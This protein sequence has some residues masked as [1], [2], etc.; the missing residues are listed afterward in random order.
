MTRVLVA[1]LG[2]IGGSLALN[3]T[4]HTD[5]TLLGYDHDPK[6]LQYAKAKGLVH[7]TYTDFETAVQKA[8]VVILSCP[9]SVTCQLIEDLNTITLTKDVLVTDVSSVKQS[10]L[11]QAEQLTNPQVHFVGGHPMAGSHKRGVE[12]AKEHLFENAIYVLTKTKSVTETDVLRLEELLASTKAK[13]IELD[14]EEH[15]EMTSVIS[16]FP[17]LIASSLVHQA[18]K[19]QEKHPTIPT[20]AAGGFRDITRIASSNPQMWQDILFQNKTVIKRL[21]KDWIEEMKQLYHMLDSDESDAMHSY[22]DQAK[23]YRD[24]LDRKGRGAL[25]S[26]YD[27]YVDIFDQPGALKKVVTLLAEAEISIKNIEILEVREGITGVLRLSFV[28]KDDQLMSHRL[29]IQ[30]GYETMLED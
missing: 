13:F 21:L 20:L 24:G 3:L 1:G 6:T 10:V 22:L 19:W 11:K 16:H 5:H 26:F 29:L 18:E 12:A 14:G 15:D 27:V 2:L 30:H 8:E 28:S 25:M 23:K 17:H 4:S 9:V 7:E